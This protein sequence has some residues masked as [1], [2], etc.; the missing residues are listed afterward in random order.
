[1]AISFVINLVYLIILIPLVI[2]WIG[3]EKTKLTNLHES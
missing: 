1:M 3:T 2:K